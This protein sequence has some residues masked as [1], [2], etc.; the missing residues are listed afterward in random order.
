MLELDESW[1]AFN[2]CIKYVHWHESHL[3]MWHQIPVILK[4]S[5][6]CAGY[7]LQMSESE[8]WVFLIQFYYENVPVIKMKICTL[9]QFYTVSYGFVLLP[10]LIKRL[11]EYN[12][13]PL[14]AL[15]LSIMAD[16]LMP[17]CSLPITQLSL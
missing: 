15:P 3:Y 10:L 9:L 6:H 5:P 16:I 14:L 7:Y 4:P 17:D 11:F 8:L 1:N 12:L 13:Q 2:W